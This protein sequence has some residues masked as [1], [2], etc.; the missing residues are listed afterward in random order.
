[1]SDDYSHLYHI[2]YQQSSAVSPIASSPASTTSSSSSS[3]K[4]S[5][6]NFHVCRRTAT[7]TTTSHDIAHFLDPAYSK[8]Q[9]QPHMS[10]SSSN[11]HYVDNIETHELDFRLF[12]P[13]T[14]SPKRRDFLAI[15]ST[16][17]EDEDE[18]DTYSYWAEEEKENNRQYHHRTSFDSYRSPSRASD[19]IYTYSNYQHF[20]QSYAYR[21]ANNDWYDEPSSTTGDVF[22]LS[23]EERQPRSQTRSR[24]ESNKLR[25]KKLESESKLGECERELNEFDDDEKFE[26][27][28]QEDEKEK[29]R[30]A[31]SMSPLSASTTHS[32][33]RQWLALR[34]RTQFAA[35]R[36][37]RNMSKLVRYATAAA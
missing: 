29:G 6:K 11:H 15:L 37:R 33:R 36:A 7:T 2:R 26:Q 34:L 21:P 10:S 8:Q 31:R 5:L 12:A 19:P 17:D 22:Y 24:R 14:H 18:K 3:S 13:A 30:Q 25:R 28:Q 1:M 35:F 27:S 4:L 32:F 23:D 16:N 9:S 20:D